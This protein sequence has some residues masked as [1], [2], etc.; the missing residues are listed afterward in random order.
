MSYGLRIYRPDSTLS[1][2]SGMLNYV[3]EGKYTG[4]TTVTSLTPPIAFT[5]ATSNFTAPTPAR[6]SNLGGNSWSVTP[7]YWNLEVHPNNLHTSVV[8][9]ALVVYIFVSKVP[10]KLGYGLRITDSADRGFSLG[11]ADK[12][13]IV[14]KR[15]FLDVNTFAK[16][17]TDTYPT[18][19][20]GRSIT[21]PTA[22]GSWAFT[23][24]GGLFANR[25]PFASWGDLF[26]E[27][28]FIQDD[29]DGIHHVVGGISS[30]AYL[31]VNAITTL[32][33]QVTTVDHGS[34]EQ[35]TEY[36]PVWLIDTFWYD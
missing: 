28:Q 34:N 33:G 25:P 5:R 3:F 32:G 27:L 13:L 16:R 29:H 10:A 8:S 35:I 36:F 14:K 6:V 17:L 20:H 9:P 15:V 1:L 11:T 2:T 12:P 18:A 21:L 7:S 4:T 30:H 23:I 22:Q 31:T 24:G 19:N 26:G